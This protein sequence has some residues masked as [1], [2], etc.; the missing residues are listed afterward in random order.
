MTRAFDASLSHNIT[1]AAKDA[2]KTLSGP[3][4]TWA[5]WKAFMGIPQEGD[6]AP[7][8]LRQMGRLPADE[9]W[10]Y[11]VTDKLQKAVKSV[12]LRVQVR[13]DESVS[14]PGSPTQRRIYWD[15]VD[16]T[17]SRDGAAE[18]L[19]YLLDDVNPEWHGKQLQGYVEAADVIHGGSYVIKARGPL[20][21][22][23]QEVYWLPAPNV[24]PVR[25]DGGSLVR[26]YDYRPDGTGTARRYAPE[27]VIPFRRFNLLDPVEIVSPWEAAR[28]DIATSRRAAEWNSQLLGNYGIPPGAWV[29][30]K[31][32]D[33][34]PTELNSIKRALRAIR[35]QRGAGKIPVLPGGLNWV[36][37]SM[38]QK[39]ADWLSSRKVSRMTIC[40]V[41]DVPLVIAGD[42]EHAGVYAGSRD[43]ERIMWRITIIPKLKDRA[44]TW[45]SFLVPDFDKTRR[46]LRVAYDITKVEALKAPP[47]EEHQSWQHWVDRGLP[48]NRAIE[49]F[50]LGGPVEGGDESKLMKQGAVD[51]VNFERE[52][53]GRESEPDTESNR[54][55]IGDGKEAIRSL[56]KRLYRHPAVK[57]YI[58]SG[59]HAALSPLTDDVDT[60]AEGLRRRLSAEQI[61]EQ[62]D[63]LG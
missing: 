48:L 18:D 45:N 16:E 34:A 5:H 3:A 40:A 14:A 11:T 7:S 10:V 6:G 13:R 38:T 43:A 24:E 53:T 54:M 12:E 57:A 4:G 46:K 37:L 39:D 8:G 23:P 58:E 29:A 27:D 41:A 1:E 52:N 2:F 47:A 19:Q 30:D 20:R 32:S 49:N 51:E 35:G 33:F 28:F 50:S 9:A 25:P 17:P 63:A 62:W 59:D 60:L 26:A 56:G 42:D 61:V 22:P 36:P 55:D 31:D 44:A 15:D 21:G